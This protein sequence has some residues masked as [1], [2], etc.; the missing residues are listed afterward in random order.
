MVECAW[1]QNQ[2]TKQREMRGDLI[3]QQELPDSIK[4]SFSLID[5]TELFSKSGNDQLWLA[6]HPFMGSLQMCLSSVLT[7][8]CSRTSI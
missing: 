8:T 4:G 7:S 2:L 3:A 5:Q 6:R 1:P